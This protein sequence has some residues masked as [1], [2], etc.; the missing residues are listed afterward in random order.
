[1]N[2]HRTTHCLVA[3][4]ATCLQAGCDRARR[5]SSNS[6]LVLNLG[7]VFQVADKPS[8]PL[9]KVFI[10]SRLLSLSLIYYRWLFPDCER[11]RFIYT[12]HPCKQPGR[13]ILS[14]PRSQATFPILLLDLRHPD[15]LLDLNYSSRSFCLSTFA[16]ALPL[17]G[18]TGLSP[19]A[20]E[21]SNQVLQYHFCKSLCLNSQ[22]RSALSEHFCKL[23]FVLLVTK[24]ELNGY[25]GLYSKCF[26]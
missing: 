25:C 2:L 7:T 21:H 17:P 15:P 6:S 4:L 14:C 1:M 11:K 22:M 10:Y 5:A 24:K 3:S 13:F 23:Y 19:R 8:T 9:M 18:G 12:I 26:P 16:H 20:C